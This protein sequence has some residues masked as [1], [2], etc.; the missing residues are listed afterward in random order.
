LLGL[1]SAPFLHTT[2]VPGVRLEGHDLILD[3]AL[4]VPP[5]RMTGRVTEVRVHGDHLLLVFGTPSPAGAR[6]PHRGNYIAYRGGQL[7]FGTLTLSD[8]NLVLIDMDP[9]DPFEISLEHYKDQVVAGYTT[10]RPDL[11]LRVFMRDF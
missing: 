3:P 1:T 8:T 2:T 6:S 11:G 10:I 7:R 9:Q 5:P 4:L